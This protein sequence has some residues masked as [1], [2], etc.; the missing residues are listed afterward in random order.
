MDKQ[1]VINKIAEYYRVSRNADF[2][3]FFGVSPQ[4]AVSWMKDGRYNIYE[5]YNRCPDINPE[6]L[7]SLGEKGEML[8]EKV[9][10]PESDEDAMTLAKSVE[11]VHNALERVAEEQAI[12]RQ[13]LSHVDKVLALVNSC[14]GEKGE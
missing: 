2:A 14:K 11:N 5:V 12:S 1:Q 10:M 7:L 4:V 3:E 8:R 6:W 9:G 13:V